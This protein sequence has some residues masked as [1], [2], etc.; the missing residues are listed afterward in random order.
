MVFFLVVRYLWRSGWVHELTSTDSQLRHCFQHSIF[1]LAEW[2]KRNVTR[3]KADFILN[4]KLEELSPFLLKKFVV[5]S[6]C[7]CA[8]ARM[9]IACIKH[10]FLCQT[11]IVFHQHKDLV[12]AHKLRNWRCAEQ[13][14][15][16]CFICFKQIVIIE[17]WQ[18]FL[19]QTQQRNSSILLE[20]VNSFKC[21][22]VLFVSFLFLKEA[23]SVIL[24]QTISFLL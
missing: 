15:L 11:W 7:Y 22:K 5:K 24:V 6:Y 16:M 2:R 3:K 19:T 1:S 18:S 13:L 20:L 23:W 8:K 9:F 10:V 21:Q 12:C 4:A 14:K 17:R